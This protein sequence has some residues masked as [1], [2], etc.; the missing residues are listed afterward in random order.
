MAMERLL[1][2]IK[3]ALTLV[4]LLA[5]VPDKTRAIIFGFFLLGI[6]GISFLVLGLLVAVVRA[7]SRVGM[8]R[9]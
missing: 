4:G 8:R 9:R 2:A 6:V 5:L 3:W 1:R 7:G